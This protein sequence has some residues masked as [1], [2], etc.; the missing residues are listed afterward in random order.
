MHD[1]TIE[2]M[3]FLGLADYKDFLLKLKETRIGVQYYLK[4]PRPVDEKMVTS[5]VLE[6]KVVLDSFSQEKIDKIRDD[7]SSHIL[8]E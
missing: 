4:K 3:P 5:F 1:C 6:C 7:I 2:L 8:G